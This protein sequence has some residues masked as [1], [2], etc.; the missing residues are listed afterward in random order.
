MQAEHGTQWWGEVGQGPVL[1]RKQGPG[2]QG[3]SAATGIALLPLL[4]PVK[5]A[6]VLQP[7]SYLL[8]VAVK[9]GRVQEEAQ[10]GGHGRVEVCRSVGREGRVELEGSHVSPVSR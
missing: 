9:V 8:V 7:S 2:S 10:L 3:L 6:S 1:R 4:H 5:R